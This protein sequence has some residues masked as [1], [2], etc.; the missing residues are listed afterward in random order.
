MIKKA[1]KVVLNTIILYIKMIISVIL[2]LVSTR[3]VLSS[4]GATDYGIFN[5]L[6]GVIAM[7]SFLNVSMTIA[8]QRFF[9]FYLGVGDEKKLKNIYVSSLLLHFLF[10][11][12]IVIIL[13]FM[14]LFLF[15][16]FLNIPAESITQAK[17]I[18]QFMVV[19]VFFTIT[20]VPYDAIINAYEDMTVL[21]V[22][23]IAESLGRLLAALSLVYV[24]SDNLLRWYGLLFAIVTILVSV[25]KRLYC[26][27]K[28][29]ILKK[30]DWKVD[31][32]L[33]KELFSFGSWNL[34]GTM[35]GI[36]RNQGSAVVLN[37]F[38]GPTINAAYGIANQLN[39]QLSSFAS[40]MTTS[41]YPQIVKSEGAGERA[42]F[43]NLTMVSSK[44]SF[45]IWCVIVLPLIPNLD[46]IL[47]L[48]LGTVPAYTTLFC[49][50]IIALSL[51]LSLTSGIQ[52]AIQA[53]GQIKIYQFVIG[54]INL[55]VPI[56][57]IVFFLYTS[58]FP[59]MILLIMLILE[60]VAGYFRLYFFCLYSGVSKLKYANIVLIPCILISLVVFLILFCFCSFEVCCTPLIKIT[61]SYLLGT[62][63]LLFLL[64][65]FALTNYEKDKLLELFDSFSLKICNHFGRK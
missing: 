47:N 33:L 31:K 5:L 48:W 57:G 59:Y 6:A 63:V 7:L 38:F 35:C 46:F 12:C 43:V 30:I 10:G 23:G 51:V 34:F 44:F 37:V 25:F 19:S 18:Y 55:F 15:D 53:M 16:G 2:T 11:L 29:L 4:L 39:G 56:G 14:S 13:E 52:I 62:S 17:Y 54:L 65:K 58:Q 28:Y 32:I 61:L 20:V 41:I 21:A 27:S 60:I 50:L 9:S 49:Q 1:D 36:A 40:N 42:R 22:F 26:H 8:T 45:F 64:S 3:L 24:F